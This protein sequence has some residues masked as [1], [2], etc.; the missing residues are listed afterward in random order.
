MLL[1]RWIARWT[2]VVAR[3][4]SWSLSLRHPIAPSLLPSPL[5]LYWCCKNAFKLLMVV[6]AGLP[7]SFLRK[8]G[9]IFGPNPFLAPHSYRLA[10]RNCLHPLPPARWNDILLGGTWSLT[11]RHSVSIESALTRQNRI[12]RVQPH[13]SSVALGFPT[14]RTL[15]LLDYSTTSILISQFT[16]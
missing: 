8:N 13:S 12:L 6:I 11:V 7:Y 16:H 14:R 2:K 10:R 5:S 15:Q 9:N 3:W 1:H 4:F